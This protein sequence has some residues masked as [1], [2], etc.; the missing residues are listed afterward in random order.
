MT[1]VLFVA[2]AREGTVSDVSRELA[3][4][5]AALA[6]MTQGSAVAVVIGAGAS[7]LADQLQ[8]AG[9]DEIVVAPTENEHFE[10]H[11]SALV[12]SSLIADRRPAAVLLAH[13]VDSMGFGPA[14]AASGGLG[15][16]SD[17]TALTWEDGQLV[18]SRGAYGGKLV[19]HQR[20]AAD[21]PVLAMLRPGSFAA[22]GGGGSPRRT[23]LAASPAAARSRHLG[24]VRAESGGAD[25]TA[26]DVLLSIGRGVEDREEVPRY[27]ELA[28]AIGGMLT[29]SRP[30]VDAGWLPSSR[31][32]GQS[33]KT[34]K[35]KVYLALGISGAVQHLAG[36]RE[37]GTVIAVNTD[38]EAPIF[39]VADY[40]AVA[41]L[42]EVAEALLPH[43]E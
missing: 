24:F 37:A 13:S 31:Q 7:A 43:F 39:G 9:I 2:E 22:A 5:A 25:I 42:E 18:A 40:G 3:G 11:V 26:A 32:V 19:A 10:P 12:L 21:R 28:T 15:F 41:D 14:V 30:L 8:L 4:A 23:T 34:V 38:P 27:E 33:G 1:D 29:A 17:V 20:F 36:I 6:A 35:P 16:S